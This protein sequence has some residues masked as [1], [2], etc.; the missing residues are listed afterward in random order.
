M[1]GSDPHT[2]SSEINMSMPIF[3]EAELSL[4]SRTR[5]G[6]LAISGHAILTP[7]MMVLLMIT[8]DF[9][10]MSATTDN[11]IP[12]QKPNAWRID[13]LTIAGTVLGLVDLAF[14]IAV[15]AV[16]KYWLG[17]GVDALQTLT[18]V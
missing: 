16:G 12:S 3:D 5:L 6:G 11:V 4:D 15:L 2:T 10:A 9:L 13:S 17:L 8:G 18:V 7:L 14:C 1:F